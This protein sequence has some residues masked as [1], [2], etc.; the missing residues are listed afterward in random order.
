MV[1]QQS[2]PALATLSAIGHNV[3]NP[4]NLMKIGQFICLLLM[5]TL[6]SQGQYYDENI[7]TTY[8]SN[9]NDLPLVVKTELDSIIT[10]NFKHY[11][12]ILLF[13]RAYRINIPPL[14]FYWLS[15]K[16]APFY[17]VMY[18]LNMPEKGIYA[19][20]SKGS[21]YTFVFY[22]DSSGTL[23]EPVN[24]PS[25]FINPQS[26][27]SYKHARRISRALWHNRIN[28]V[29]GGLVLKMN[30]NTFEWRFNRTINSG[31]FNGK[32]KYQEIN[33]NALNGEVIKNEIINSFI[34]D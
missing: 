22:F 31:R 18:F 34:E 26:I 4:D 23:L 17:E 24:L 25:E 33:I 12:N 29:S 7:C 5:L 28:K 9:L 8:Y 20:H 19:D 27:I 11:K 2:I 30:Q 1:E 6:K 15:G 21:Y 14:E 3:E 10:F 13:H 16:E 32:Y